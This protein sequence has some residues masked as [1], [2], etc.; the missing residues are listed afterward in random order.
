M[1]RILTVFNISISGFIV[2]TFLFRDDLKSLDYLKYCIKESNRLYPPVPAVCRELAESKTFDG[3]TLPKGTWIAINIYTVHH[4][5][6][7]WN[8]PEVKEYN[9]TCICIS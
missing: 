1:V 5:P 2:H 9:Y 6:H 3:Y 8:E 4:N 7:V